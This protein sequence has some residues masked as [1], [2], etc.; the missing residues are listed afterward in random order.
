MLVDTVQLSRAERV[1][2]IP[3]AISM[4]FHMNALSSKNKFD[5]ILY[6]TASATIILMIKT[7][8]LVRSIK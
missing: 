6:G 3:S 5:F 1:C 8:Y 4:G 7:I 2:Y